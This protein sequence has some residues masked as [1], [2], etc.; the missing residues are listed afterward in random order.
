MK[1]SEH[2]RTIT[3]EIICLLYIVLFVYA[4]ASK[5]L[6]FENFQVQLGQSPLL[7]AFAGWVS[8]GVPIIELMISLL[9]IFRRYRLVGLYAAFGIMVMFTSYIVI[10]LNFSSFVPCSC[11]GILEKLGW[12][13]HLFFNV[14]FIALA[15]IGILLIKADKGTGSGIRVPILVTAICSSTCVFGLFLLSEDMIHN[16]NNFIRRFPNH[17]ALLTNEFNLKYTSYYIAGLDQS[18]IYLANVKAPLQLQLIDTSLQR[19][20]IITIKL[21]KTDFVFRSVKV[22]VKPPYFYVSDGTVPCIFRGKVSDWKASLWMHGKA[23]FTH[24]EPVTPKKVAIRALSSKNHEN[25]LGTIDFQDNVEV[26]VSDELLEKQIDGVFDTDGMLLYNDKL[27]KLIYTYYYRNEYLL[28][29]DLLRL[30]SVG[31]TIDTTSKAKITVAYINSRKESKMASPPFSVNK[32]TATFGNYLFVQA[33]LIGKYES[34]EMWDVASIVDVYDLVKKTYVFSF[35]ISDKNAVKMSEFR[36]L[37]DLVVVLSGK[38]LSTY[39]LNNRF[40]ENK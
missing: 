37:D 8:W 34:F 15:F 17:L 40:Y 16:R 10:I 38:Y 3:I 14:I 4:A 25:I 7:S 29:D 5:L 26:H 28:V 39:R 11:G 33:S 2:T 6:D 20:E 9:L 22:Q 18:T 19:Q 30:E 35:Y 31:K 24:M 36:V 12:T 23:Y 13:E 1:F 32:N 27:R 21:P